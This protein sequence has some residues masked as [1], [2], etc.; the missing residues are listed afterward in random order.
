MSQ[1]DLLSKA[2]EKAWVGGFEFIGIFC[3]EKGNGGV[4]YE[5]AEQKGIETPI[6]NFSSCCSHIGS[7]QNYCGNYIN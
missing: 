7:V 6:E 3:R 5:K 1:T 4:G 2:M